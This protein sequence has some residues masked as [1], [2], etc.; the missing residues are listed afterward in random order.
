MA[1]VSIFV[2]GEIDLDSVL[3]ALGAPLGLGLFGGD[4]LRDAPHFSWSIN[5]VE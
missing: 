5:L 1:V 4:F 3:L 2:E